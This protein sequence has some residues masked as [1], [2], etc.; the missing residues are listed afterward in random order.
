MKNLMKYIPKAYKKLVVDIREGAEEYNE[1]TRRTQ[2]TVI[3]EWENGEKTSFNNKSWM[4]ESL[5]QTHSPEEF[6]A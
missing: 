1:I 4:R 3:V 6:T 5:N 2:K